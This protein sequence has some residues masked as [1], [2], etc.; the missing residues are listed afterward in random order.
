MRF[1]RFSASVR[2]PKPVSLFALWM[3]FDCQ[4]VQYS[5]SSW[6]VRPKGWGSWLPIKICM[7][8]QKKN[9]TIQ[10]SRNEEATH[11]SAANK[12]LQA[13]RLQISSLHAFLNNK[14]N[15]FSRTFQVSDFNFKDPTCHRLMSVTTLHGFLMRTI[16]LYNER[17]GQE[18]TDSN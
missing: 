3:L 8:E 17:A 9:M 7:Q 15:Y 5:L 14:F 10:K 16:Y 2:R 6:T 12:T 1:S 4:S 13:S 11:P 18:L